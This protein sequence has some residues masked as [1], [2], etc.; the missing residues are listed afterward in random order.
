[1]PSRKHPGTKQAAKVIQAW[2]K[3]YDNIE[4]HGGEV[5]HIS[6][7]QLRCLKDQFTEEQISMLQ[8]YP[9]PE[10]GWMLYTPTDKRKLKDGMKVFAAAAFTFTYTTILMG[11]AQGAAV[12][13]TT[14]LLGTYTVAAAAHNGQR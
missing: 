14:A 4:R 6:E 2:L 7:E 13:A 1:M 9:H 11:P 5:M 3:E 10:G 12:G 8:K